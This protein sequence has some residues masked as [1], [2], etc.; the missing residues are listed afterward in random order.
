[1]KRHLLTLVIAGLATSSGCTRDVDRD[2]VDNAEVDIN[3]VA[4]EYRT[5]RLITSEPAEVNPYLVVFC[6]SRSSFIENARE[7]SGPHAFS[8][9]NIYMNDSA[10]DA[11]AAGSTSY[12]TGSVVVKEKLGSTVDDLGATDGVG[13]MVKRETGYD[14]D[15]G[16][17]EYFYFDTPD[18]IETGR[19][20]SCVQCHERAKATDYVFGSWSAPAGE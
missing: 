16:D 10:A 9:I 5:L 2:E 11:F 4:R 19:I 12:P 6:I 13:G 15:H 7:R 1:M 8:K 3:R 14:P 18:N 20:E 17:W